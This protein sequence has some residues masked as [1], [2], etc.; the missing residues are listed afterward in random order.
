MVVPDVMPPPMGFACGTA[1]DNYTATRENGCDSGDPVLSSYDDTPYITIPPVEFETFY[2]AFGSFEN[3]PDDNRV[4]FGFPA[5]LPMPGEEPIDWRIALPG[6]SDPNAGEAMDE[7]GWGDTYFILSLD[8]MDLE[9]PGGLDGSS[10]WTAKAFAW[11]GDDYV[12]FPAETLATLPAVGSVDALDLENQNGGNLL[13]IARLQVHRTANWIIGEDFRDAD[14][15]AIFDVNTEWQYYFQN[16]NSC[17][18]GI[19]NDGDGFCDIEGCRDENDEYMPPDEACFCEESDDPEERYDCPL[20]ETAA[21]NDNEDNDEDGLVD[22]DDPD[23]Y[24]ASGTFD[25]NDTDEG[26]T[27]GDGVDNDEDGWIDVADPGCGG[28]AAGSDE[29]GYS[30]GSDCNDS[31]DNDGDGR[32]DALDPGC[33]TGLDSED[34]DTCTDGI[35]NNEDGWIDS[36]DLTCAPG[37][38]YADGES[39]YSTLASL[40]FECSSFDMV[41][42]PDGIVAQPIDEDGDGEANLDDEDCLWGWDASGE[43]A[44]PDECHDRIDNDLDGWVDDADYQCVGF[45]ESES[46]GLAS[47]GNCQDG[48]DNDGDGWVDVLDPDCLTSADDEVFIT[49]LA[50]NNQLDDDGDGDID[51]ADSDCLTGKDNH[52]DE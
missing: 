9:R 19:D 24:D 14:G 30:Y 17:Y 23:C 40:A 15:R 10:V 47:A 3:A 2:W 26:P 33:S 39:V 51:S 18:D 22:E 5:L 6:G 38:Y 48:Q 49:G 8:V 13:G 36:D 12:T 7:D 52:E 35:D 43:G 27:C 21:C 44:L 37:S 20:L 32:T 28:T 50:C 16:Q 41:T 31:I 34:G 4:F 45:P 46:E 29:G 1:S 11:A 25:A 42:T